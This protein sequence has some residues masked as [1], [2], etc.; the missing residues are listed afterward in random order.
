VVKDTTTA[1]YDFESC[2]SFDL[3]DYRGEIKWYGKWWGS[4]RPLLPFRLM[5]EAIV[6]Q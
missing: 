1:L 4:V 2:L 6:F 3:E 5:Q